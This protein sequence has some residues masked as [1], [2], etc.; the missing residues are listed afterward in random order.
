MHISEIDRMDIIKALQ[1]IKCVCQNNICSECPFGDDPGTKCDII[2][3]GYPENWA[4]NDSFWRAF[5]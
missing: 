1:V 3:N 2:Q 4:I 5:K